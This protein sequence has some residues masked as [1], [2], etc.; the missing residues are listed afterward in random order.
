MRNEKLSAY[1]ADRGVA[2]EGTDMHRANG[3]ALPGGHYIAASVRLVGE[4]A[5]K[6]LA[7]EAAHV[8]AEHH[9]STP[10]EEAKTVA[11]TSASVARS[12]SASTAPGTS[13]PTWSGG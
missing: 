7:H 6:M 2:L 13:S 11:E 9:G 1:L 8:T 10:R 3:Y 4:R 12:R 5:T